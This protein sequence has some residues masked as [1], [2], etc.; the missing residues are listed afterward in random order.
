MAFTGS[1]FFATTG[2]SSDDVRQ[3]PTVLEITTQTGNVYTLKI[4]GPT[5]GAVYNGSLYFGKTDVFPKQDL[6]VETLSLEYTGNATTW[7]SYR[8]NC[9]DFIAFIPK[10][11]FNQSYTSS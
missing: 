6:E 1:G 3:S 9:W 4:S 7:N 10:I 5:V 11:Q 2:V 8:S